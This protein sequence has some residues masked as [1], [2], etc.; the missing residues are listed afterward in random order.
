MYDKLKLHNFTAFADAEFEFVRGVNAYVGAN[1]S[2]KTHVLKLLYALQ[3]HQV[4]ASDPSNREALDV[5][6]MSV[7]NPD[8]LGRLVRRKRGHSECDVEAIWRGEGY[9]RKQTVRFHL[10]P[11]ARDVDLEAVWR[12]DYL[13]ILIPAKDILGNSVNFVDAY[14]TTTSGRRWLDFDVTY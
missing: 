6:L 13:P 10:T 5:T 8:S 14:D 12:I 9:R 7:F 11:K 4:L 2:G 1:G 3:K